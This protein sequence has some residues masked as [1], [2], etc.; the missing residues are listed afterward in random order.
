[1]AKVRQTQNA[2]NVTR[3]VWRTTYDPFVTFSRILLQFSGI[4]KPD[5]PKAGFYG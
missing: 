1:M 2:P 3:G 5:D 4:L